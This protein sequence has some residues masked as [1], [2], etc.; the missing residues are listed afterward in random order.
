MR[1][2][3]VGGGK[4]GYYLVK[5]LKEKKHQVV[6][7]EK[8]IDICQ[9]IAEEIQVDVICGDGSDVEVLKDAGIEEAEV[10]AAVTGKDEENLVI[11]Q[12]AKVNFNINETIARINNPKNTAIFKALGVD[13]TVCSTQVICNLIEGE[14]NSE[15]LKVIE[16]INRGEMILVEAKIDKDSA[17]KDKS[18]E[19]LKLPKECLI[20]SIIRSEKVIFPRGGEDIKEGDKVLIIT[21]TDRKKDVEKSIIGG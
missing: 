3:I 9:K 15:P 7:I 12:M 6:L 14:F 11:C 10:V 1:A 17:W 4:V 2:V 5:A 13:K 16:S 8:D 21:N 18:I 20:I 19:K